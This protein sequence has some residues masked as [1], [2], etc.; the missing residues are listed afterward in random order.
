[1]IELPLSTPPQQAMF[2][3]EEPKS[4]TYNIPPMEF[5]FSPIALLAY[6]TLF[7]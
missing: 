7:Y 3:K 2:E 1:M 4:L 5:V 6:A